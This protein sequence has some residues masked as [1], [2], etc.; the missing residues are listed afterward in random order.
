MFELEK[1]HNNI[2]FNF[3]PD[4]LENNFIEEYAFWKGLINEINEGL[5]LYNPEI[6]HFTY[7]EFCQSFKE[8]ILKNDETIDLS[9]INVCVKNII[10]KKISKR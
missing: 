2:N 1:S 4:N 3:N 9:I 6:L 7:D 8:E 5:S 10:F